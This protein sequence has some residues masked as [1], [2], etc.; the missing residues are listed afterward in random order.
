MVWLH[1]LVD[2]IA[3]I[4]DVVTWAACVF[5]WLT[6][7]SNDETEKDPTTSVLRIF[8]TTEIEVPSRA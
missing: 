8:V 7:A 1:V 5:H 6:L 2:A 4:K 3:L